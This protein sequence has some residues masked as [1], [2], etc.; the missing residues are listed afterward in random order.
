MPG[1]MFFPADL[2]TINRLYKQLRDS[3]W[4]MVERL[5]GVVANNGLNNVCTGA[6]GLPDYY[7]G[8]TGRAGGGSTLAGAAGSGASGEGAEPALQNVADACKAALDRHFVVE[9]TKKDDDQAAANSGSVDSTSTTM[10]NGMGTA[11]PSSTGASAS[12]SAAT[13]AENETNK[14]DFIMAELVVCKPSKRPRAES[15]G[16]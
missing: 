9:D 10:T 11:M 5:S 15:A 12:S 13:T 4:P 14:P 2:V 3:I 8:S 7:T 16:P 6:V 1:N